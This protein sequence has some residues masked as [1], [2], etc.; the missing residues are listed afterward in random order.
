MTTTKH[1]AAPPPATPTPDQGTT[2]TIPTP[3]RR[4][5]RPSDPRPSVALDPRSAAA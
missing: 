3:A 4:H 1:H 2:T 5:P